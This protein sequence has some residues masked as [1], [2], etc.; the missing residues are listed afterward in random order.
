MTLT[1]VKTTK[2]SLKI[3]KTQTNLHKTDHKTGKSHIPT[4][5]IADLRIGDD[6]DNE[7]LKEKKTEKRKKIE[8]VP[9]RESSLSINNTYGLFQAERGMKT[10]AAWTVVSA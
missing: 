10:S 9:H 8:N 3:P 7:M 4:F 1:T 2:H 6:T 5:F